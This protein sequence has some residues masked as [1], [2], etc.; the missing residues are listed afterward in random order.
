MHKSTLDEAPQLFHVATLFSLLFWISA[1]GY[2][3]PRTARPWQVRQPVG[4]R[5]SSPLVVAR[6]AARRLARQ[7]RHRSAACCSATRGCARAGA[8]LE[9][10]RRSRPSSSADP[11]ERSRG[12]GPLHHACGELPAQRESERVI[13]APRSS[14]HG[15]VLDL[16][17][18]R[19]VARPERQRAAAAPRGPRLLGRVRRHPRHA[20]ARR[21]PLRAVPLLALRQAQPRRRRPALRP[22]WPGAACW[23]RSRSPSS[24][25][26]ADR[27]SSASGA[28]AATAGVPDAQVP[29]DGRRRRRAEG[30]AARPQRGATACSRS[31]TTRASPA[32]AGS[33][34]RTSLDELPQLFNVAARRD[35]PGRPAA[36][37]RRRGPAI[38]GWH[39]RRLHLT[40]GMTGPWQILG[41]ARIPLREMVAIDYLYVANWSLWSD[42]K[43]LLRTA[44]SSSPDA[45]S[46][47]GNARLRHAAPPGRH[48]VRSR[49][50]NRSME[51][52]A[53]AASV[54]SQFEARIAGRRGGAPVRPG[55]PLLPG[56]AGARRGATA[57]CARRSSATA[58]GSCTPRRSGG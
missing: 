9:A 18:A 55:D 51:P 15:D 11:V 52:S 22:A 36:A 20:S 7:T 39:R 1:T 33:C 19:E 56:R 8:K 12:R 49:C 6:A 21:A 38:E 40:P 48:P 29:H 27:C 16:V 24:S 5:C 3:S 35:E 37:G 47:P 46:A 17:R 31:P 4:R 28:S 45:V 23:P 53:T 14:D 44:A 26:R 41:S 2:A 34:A 32:S 42:L 10:S 58:T 57:R 30:R 25:T 13:I 54:A 43:I 50:D